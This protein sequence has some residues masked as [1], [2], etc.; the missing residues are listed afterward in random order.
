MSGADSYNAK[1]L[2][3]GAVG[4]SHLTELTRHYQVTNGLVVDGKF[5]PSTAAAVEAAVRRRVVSPPAV[6]A[7]RDWKLFD[8]PLDALPRNRSEV[9][10]MFGNPGTVRADRRWV[11]ENIVTVRDLPGVPRK[12]H[13]RLHRLAEPYVREALRR[14]QLVA[15]SYA[16]ERFGGWVFRRIR[17]NPA[18][19]LS[20]H[21]FGLA[22]DVNPADNGGKTFGAASAPRAWSREWMSWWPRGVPAA[23]VEAFQ[24][25]GFA[26]GSDWDEDGFT[27]DHTYLDPMHFE[28]VWRGGEV[29]QV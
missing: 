19:P 25:V 1:R 28:L 14:A 27:N 24:S 26:W 6:I 10:A 11:R 3:R 9:Y 7:G 13:V 20:M 23:F 15:S 22:V 18:K 2:N 29:H 8:G 16:I 4:P 12:W 17:H 5:G 21:A